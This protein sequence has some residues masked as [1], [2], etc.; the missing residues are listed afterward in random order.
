MPL[1]GTAFP[2]HSRAVSSEPRVLLAAPADTGRRLD[3]FLAE[4]LAN[5]RLCRMAPCAELAL[6]GPSPRYTFVSA[7]VEPVL[8]GP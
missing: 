4:K 3:L 5:A 2:V 8:T 6:L 1:D 7:S